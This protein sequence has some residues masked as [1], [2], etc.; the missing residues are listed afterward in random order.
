[1]DD[2][3]D[4]TSVVELMASLR[5]AD[6]QKRRYQ[7]F[8]LPSKQQL[9]DHVPVVGRTEPTPLRRYSLRIEYVSDLKIDEVAS[10][11]RKGSHGKY[12]ISNKAESS[13]SP[14]LLQLTE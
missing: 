11:N 6:W 10:S 3:C 8:S 12:C 5:D 9:I 1:M 2:K 14:A 4:V 7:T 13:L